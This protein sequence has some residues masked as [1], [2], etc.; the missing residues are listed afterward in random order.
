MD[1]HTFERLWKQE[2]AVYCYEST[3]NRVDIRGLP[4]EHCPYIVE[5]TVN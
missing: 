2:K 4:P 5:Q 1:K 3:L